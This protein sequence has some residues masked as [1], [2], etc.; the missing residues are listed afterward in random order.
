LTIF[1]LV[2]GENIKAVDECAHA[3]IS[4][5]FSPFTHTAMQYC[6]YLARQF[7][8]LKESLD[9][10]RARLAGFFKFDILQGLYEIH[11]QR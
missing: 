9:A 6:L 4:D 7:A 3:R 2:S 5:P 8:E 11:E 10:G 1:H